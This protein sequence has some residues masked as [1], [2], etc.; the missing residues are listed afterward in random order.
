M[1]PNVVWIYVKYISRSSSRESENRNI[2]HYRLKSIRLLC[3][4][5]TL[6]FVKD[7]ARQLDIKAPC[8][9]FDQ[10]LW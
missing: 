6:L 3:I 9:K 7:Q 5:S 4:Y 1:Q 8:L 10:P 2:A